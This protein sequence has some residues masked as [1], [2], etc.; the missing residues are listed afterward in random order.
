[1]TCRPGDV[2]VRLRTAHADKKRALDHYQELR[3]AGKVK[4]AVVIAEGEDGNL[5]VLGQM[6]KPEEIGELLLMAAQGLEHVMQQRQ[7]PRREALV[8]YISAKGVAGPARKVQEITTAADG[9]LVPPP[10]EHIIGCGECKHSRFYVLLDEQ[11]Q[12]ARFSCA[13]CGN[14]IKQIRVFHP[15]ARA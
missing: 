15:E 11:D 2:R 14:E 5:T 6:L 10:G 13:H 3:R 1:M 12:P 8:P 4:R 7:E 9:T